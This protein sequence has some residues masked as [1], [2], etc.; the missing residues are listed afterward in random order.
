LLVYLYWLL[1]YY[2]Y[3]YYYYSF[4]VFLVLLKG[5]FPVL[6]YLMIYPLFPILSISL[7]GLQWLISQIGCSSSLS[8]LCCPVS[9]LVDLGKG[10]TG[11][12]VA[13]GRIFLCRFILE[14][15]CFEGD[16]FMKDPFLY[17]SQENVLLYFNS[18]LYDC[19]RS[20]S[21]VCNVA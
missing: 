13:R 18:I 17:T 12:G 20:L 9:L 19:G 3:Y 6:I 7:A 4:R 2:Y 11:F 16:E 15:T 1:Y 21:C 10:R 8:N 14:N 5:S